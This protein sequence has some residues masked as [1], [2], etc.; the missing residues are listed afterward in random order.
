M[1]LGENK[2]CLRQTVRHPM[3]LKHK[4]N[5]LSGRNYKNAESLLHLH[6]SA[7]KKTTSGAENSGG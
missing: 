5:K 7:K 2:P 4:G 1:V 3:Q 6:S